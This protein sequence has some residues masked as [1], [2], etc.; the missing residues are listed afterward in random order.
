MTGDFCTTAATTDRF[1]ARL[2]AD[3]DC[4]AFGLVERGY[5][6]LSQPGSTVSIALTALLVIAVALFGYRLLLGRGIV[7]R[8]AMDLTIKIGVVLLIAT[9][10]ESWQAL[11][12][13]GL[14]RAP[15]EVAGEML[16]A[17]GAPAPLESLQKALDSLTA[18]GIGYRTRAGIASPLVG[19]PA[20]AAAVLNISAVLLTLA[21][22]GILVA[23]RDRK[24]VV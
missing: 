4:Q 15:G 1:A 3:T 16:V 5:A 8:D 24:S 19:G 13:H 21:T 17:I 6:A 12:Y 11:A 23:A 10:W 18:A 9:S 2:L 22:V 20:A 7:L 14:A